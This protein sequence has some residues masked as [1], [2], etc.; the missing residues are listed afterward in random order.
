MSRKI[1]LTSWFRVQPTIIALFCRHDKAKLYVR[2]VFALVKSR[3]V[4]LW[5]PTLLSRRHQ[6]TTKYGGR[7]SVAKDGTDIRGV[8]CRLKG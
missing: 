3:A 2:V 5:A 1:A 7:G 8:E 4:V 6:R